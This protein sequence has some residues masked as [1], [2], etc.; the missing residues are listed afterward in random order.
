MLASLR[1][2]R[3]DAYGPWSASRVALVDALAADQLLI[4]LFGPETNS[5]SGILPNH[6]ARCRG[7][8]EMNAGSYPHS[9]QPSTPC[10]DDTNIIHQMPKI[11]VANLFGQIDG[12]DKIY[13]HERAD[14]NKCSHSNK[15]PS[16]NSRSPSDKRGRGPY[17]KGSPGR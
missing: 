8:L 5:R 13:G 6:S 16:L 4:E 1:S 2:H 17:D 10:H 7:A 3:H 15:H 14:R 11:Q 9:D 12:R